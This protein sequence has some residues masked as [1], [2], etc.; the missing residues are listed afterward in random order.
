M[1]TLYYKMDTISVTKKAKIASELGVG[2]CLKYADKWMMEFDY[3]RSDWTNTGIS[4][5]SGFSESS[6]PFSASVSQAYRFGFEIVP[7][8]NDAR[9][10]FNHVAYRCGAYYKD[11]YY[12]LYGRKVSS[13]GVTLGVTLP[14][15]RWYNGLTLGMELGQ[16]GTLAD[17]MIRE[18]YINFSVGVNIFDI[19][20]QKSHYD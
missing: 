15:F 18:R 13:M 17:N 3:T 8:R 9:Y 10:Y 19:W 20:F 2:L 12:Q 6:S 14:I 5:I 7:N 11:E 4:S 16:R 1:D